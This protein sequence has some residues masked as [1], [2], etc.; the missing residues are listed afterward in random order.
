[1]HKIKI[2]TRT[3]IIVLKAFAKYGTMEK[4]AEMMNVSKNTINTHSMRLRKRLD[5]A[6]IVQAVAFGYN[7][8]ILKPDSTDLFENHGVE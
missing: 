4:V 8:G 6:T 2:L 5:V 1:M 7:S 3:Q